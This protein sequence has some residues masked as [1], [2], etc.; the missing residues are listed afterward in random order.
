MKWCCRWSLLVENTC[1]VFS[2]PWVLSPPLPRRATKA[3]KRN[4][5]RTGV[6][7]GWEE[8]RETGKGET[9][10][11]RCLLVSCVLASHIFLTP[12]DL[13]AGFS[14][15]LWQVVWPDGSWKIYQK[16]KKS[17][18]YILSRRII[19]SKKNSVQKKMLFSLHSSSLILYDMLW[20]SHSGVCPRYV[21]KCRPYKLHPW[22]N[23]HFCC[24]EKL[25]KCYAHHQVFKGYLSSL[26]CANVPELWIIAVGRPAWISAL[27]HLITV[28]TGNAEDSLVTQVY[29]KRQRKWVYFW[30]YTNLPLKEWLLCFSEDILKLDRHDAINSLSL[31]T[32]GGLPA[33]PE[34][35]WLH[36]SHQRK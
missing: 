17:R 28:F 33:I 34:L 26:L 8:K 21:S 15:K 2:R 4:R 3:I 27:F 13:S 36:N 22:E 5:E 18:C 35:C 31:F 7:K 11:K 20:L 6:K 16:Y 19:V 9:K 24:S 25:Q 12:G 1:L 23:S 30:K 32:G 29:S 14:I 10:L